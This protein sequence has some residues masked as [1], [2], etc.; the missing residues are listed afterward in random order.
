MV[1][2]EIKW[3]FMAIISD[4]NRGC[5]EVEWKFDYKYNE[6]MEE[7]ELDEDERCLS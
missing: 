7:D 2:M 5:E 4:E 1:N 3:K 6:E